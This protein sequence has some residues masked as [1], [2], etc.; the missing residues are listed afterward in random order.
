M[1]ALPQTHFFYS[2]LSH[3]LKLVESLLDGTLIA[4]LILIVHLPFF[5]LIF[6]SYC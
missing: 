4:K 3:Y 1:M 6:F 2:Y 5:M